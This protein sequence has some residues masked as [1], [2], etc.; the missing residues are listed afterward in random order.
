MLKK[1]VSILSLFFVLLMTGCDDHGH[2]HDENG[3][4]PHDAPKHH[5]S[6]K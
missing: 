1:Y 2:D 4:H 3:G 6:L 5:D